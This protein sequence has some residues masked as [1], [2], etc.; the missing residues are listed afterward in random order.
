MSPPSSNHTRHMGVML[1]SPLIMLR[2][3]HINTNKIFPQIHTLK[4]FLQKMKINACNLFLM[5]YLIT[6]SNDAGVAQG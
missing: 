2:S 4:N 6:R 3:I 5:W 1:S